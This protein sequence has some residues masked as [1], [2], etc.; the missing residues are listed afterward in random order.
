MTQDPHGAAQW[1]PAT[2]VRSAAGPL[3]LGAALG[4]LGGWLWWTWWGPAPDGKAIDP[5][6]LKYDMSDFD[7][8]AVEV[9]LRLVC[10]REFEIERFV[11]REYWSLIATL[12]TPRGETF[13]ARLVGADGN[14]HLKGGEGNDYFHASE[15]DDIAEGGSGA[16]GAAS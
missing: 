3:A 16:K 2:L 15:G 7:G 4:A 8:Y 5:S 13:E 1:R 9:A 10:D 14:D 6:G 11:P 12:A